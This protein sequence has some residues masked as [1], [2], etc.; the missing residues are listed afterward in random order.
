M[1]AKSI[2]VIFLDG[3]GLGDA[4]L[5]VNPFMHVEMPVLQKWVGVS[6]L[7]REAA[8][9]TTDEAA[10]LGIDA[11]LGV[12]G[13]PQSGTG[14][15]TILTGINAAAAL[16]EH[17]GPY[18]TQAL[19]SMLAEH[20]IFRTLRDMGHPVAYANAYPDRF[21]DRLSR[22]RGRTSANTN[23]AFMAGVPLRGR[24]DLMQGRGL[25]ALM[26]NDF[27]P[28]SHVELPT[29]TAYQ[30]G[31]YLAKI[32]QGY[33]LTFFEFWYSDR[34]G[35]KMA[36]E[37]SLWV[38]K[39]LDR[40]IAGTLA[41][42]DLSRFLLLIVSDHGNFEDWRTKKHTSNPSVAMI[43]GSGTRRIAAQLSTL[44][45]VKPAIMSYLFG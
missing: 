36:R 2:V 38:V 15:T 39:Q 19:R 30:A 8:G 4:D 25:A 10:I 13:I 26:V 16:G 18:P 35:H 6:H 21:L 29:I 5:E 31:E 42:L 1:S 28:E 23:A 33:V 3:V 20:S 22:G 11:Q 37:E 24:E 32:A 9:V 40:F 43:F 14:Q 12:P 45:D 44:T 17:C 7:T 27:W 41:G 34:V